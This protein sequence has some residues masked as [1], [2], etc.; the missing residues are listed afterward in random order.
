M[1]RFLPVVVLMALVWAGCGGKKSTS[2]TV[3]IT[4]SPT[5]ASIAGGATQQFTATVT[6]TTNTAVTWEVNGAAGGNAQIG[7]VS[8][9]GLYTAPTV[10]PSTTTV[11]V[12]AVSQADTT[13]SASATV[14]L[15]APPIV[16]SI[17]PTT[18]NL[19]AGTQQQFTATV[20]GGS[21]NVAV[22]SVNGFAGGN[23]TVGTVSSA[24][25]YTAPLSPPKESITVTAT[26]Q[27]NAAFTASAPV[28]VEFGTASL[29]GHYVF[30][31]TQ[32]D[33]SSG[34]GFAFRGGTFVADGKGNITGGV[35]DFNSS[36]GLAANVAISSGTYTVGAD[37][38]GTATIVDANGSHTF[39][40]ALTSNTRGQL[41]E[42]DNT[43]VTSGYI[44]QQDQNAIAT[45]SG[46][47]VFSLFGDNAGPF[48]AIGQMSFLNPNITATEDVNNVGTVSQ[49]TSVTGTYSVGSSGR[50]T[51]TISSILGTSQFAFYIVDASTLVLIDIDSIG[52]RTAGT[53]SA[54]STP[55]FSN[56]S[57]GSSVYFT[58]GNVTS[59]NKPY[60]QAGRFGTDG[61]GNLNAGVFDI[62]NAGAPTSN[63]PFT[64]TTYSVASTGRGTLAT[65]TSNFIFWLASS[66]MGVIMQSDSGIVASG[67]LLQ[68]TTGVT[69]VTGGFEFVVA[70]ATAA[71]STLQALGAQ[72]TT[73]G[74]G[75]L[76]GTA[77]MNAT[78]GPVTSTASPAALTGGFAIGANG[79]A[80]TGNNNNIKATVTVNG[81]S[82]VVSN[83]S[84][85]FYFVS[86]DRFVMLTSDTA[87]V[88]SGI[89]ERQCSDCTF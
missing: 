3:A 43:G 5:T 54:Q 65:G 26:S 75:V 80:V 88:L 30:L 17:S 11:S 69:G 27:D 1:K 72:I 86:P 85:V 62:N 84:Y 35:T 24:G 40:F 6:N 38:R 73:S 81:T 22:W 71:G 37:G 7:T 28:T 58:S 89:A 12:T 64:S 66:K 15:T 45:V 46:P 51:A 63:G 13:Q 29:N 20:S 70:G 78:G 18:A 79:R 14:T 19:V 55:T 68:Q 2:T 4:I 47:F 34:T 44:R 23:S 41:I 60:G 39:A 76:V 16:I 56:A 74:L 21:T 48:A 31:A 42:F 49:I 9:S 25:L 10:L 59:G 83:D 87:A 57:L 32:R 67:L 52:V 82:T 53:A 50:G 61:A 77:D 8:T 33:N 36:A